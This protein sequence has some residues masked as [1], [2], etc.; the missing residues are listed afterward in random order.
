MSDT[1]LCVTHKQKECSQQKI[2]MFILSIFL[3]DNLCTRWYDINYMH[4]SIGLDSDKLRNLLQAEL[5][6]IYD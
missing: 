3:L 4:M 6:K 5:C 2:H 1:R